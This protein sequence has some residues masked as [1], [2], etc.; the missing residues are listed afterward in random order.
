MDIKETKLKLKEKIREIKAWFTNGS[1]KLAD[2]MEEFKLEGNN[3]DKFINNCLVE[4][5]KIEK[6]LNE[7]KILKFREEID[8]YRHF[9]HHVHDVNDCDCCEKNLENIRDILKKIDKMFGTPS[10]PEAN[11]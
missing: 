5:M 4:G 3:I 10:K 8:T 9:K 7:E 2:L 1:L 11:K 6:E